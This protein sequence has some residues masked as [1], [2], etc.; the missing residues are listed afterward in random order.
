MGGCFNCHNTLLWKLLFVFCVCFKL[1]LGAFIRQNVFQHLRQVSQQGIVS[2]VITS[3]AS[4][5]KLLGK[6]INYVLGSQVLIANLSI[7]GEH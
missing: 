1:S 6:I 4:N 2:S 7:C 3:M 5:V